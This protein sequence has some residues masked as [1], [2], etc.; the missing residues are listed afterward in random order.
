MKYHEFV[1]HAM[2]S[3]TPQIPPQ[4][5]NAFDL[6]KI[7]SN[8]IGTKCMQSAAAGSIENTDPAPQTT[9]WPALR[10]LQTGELN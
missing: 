7:C 1:M 4:E 10:R 5:L 2:W 3:Q 9:H 6:L 8:N